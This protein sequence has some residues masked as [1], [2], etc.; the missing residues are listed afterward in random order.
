MSLYRLGIFY[1][2]ASLSMFLV[3]GGS[4]AADLP[5]WLSGKPD[6]NKIE[7][8]SALYEWVLRQADEQTNGLA[9]QEALATDR[10]RNLSNK[11]AVY[12]KHSDQKEFSA[13]LRYLVF[14]ADQPMHFRFFIT[15]ETLRQLLKK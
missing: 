4:Q 13:E 8:R 2:L 3:W 15:D 5:S 9:S 11:L 6:L 14:G 10:L 12:A 1:L 7:E